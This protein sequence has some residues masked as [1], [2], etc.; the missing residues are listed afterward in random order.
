ML[1]SKTFIKF[2][3]HFVKILYKQLNILTVV[4]HCKAAVKNLAYENMLIE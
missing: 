3:K 4:V 1:R 2:Y